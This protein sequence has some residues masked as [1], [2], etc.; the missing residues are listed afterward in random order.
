M[1]SRLHQI[2]KTI[3]TITASGPVF[4][5]EIRKPWTSGSTVQN[6]QNPVKKSG[7]DNHTHLV[8]FQV[9]FPHPSQR[10]VACSD[11][12]Q[13]STFEI[14]RCS[15]EFTFTCGCTSEQFQ[16]FCCPYKKKKTKNKPTSVPLTFWEL[17]LNSCELNKPP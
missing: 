5:M 2:L 11:F 12:R 9:P 13:G 4:K 7:D 15:L 17:R 14:H 16:V 3:R 6:V 10:S 1:I 8:A